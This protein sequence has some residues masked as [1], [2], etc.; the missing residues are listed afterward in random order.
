M[1]AFIQPT[2]PGYS[3]WAQSRQTTPF[4]QVP[5]PQG[6]QEGVA[7]GQQTALSPTAE[8]FSDGTEPTAPPSS[9]PQNANVWGMFGGQGGA[10]S[11][12]APNNGD[13]FGTGNI[14][15]LMAALMGGA[16]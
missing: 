1:S 9:V 11:S 10:V 12:S 13:V 5:G 15:A 8:F 14:P 16:R 6:L 2:I 3:P 7:G 4:L